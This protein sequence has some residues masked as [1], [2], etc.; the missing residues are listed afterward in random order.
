MYEIETEDA[1][2]DM[3]NDRDLFDFAGYPKTSE[4]Y[5]PTNNKVIGKFKDE[6]NG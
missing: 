2:L 1:Y 4:Y 3:W 5:D 6:A